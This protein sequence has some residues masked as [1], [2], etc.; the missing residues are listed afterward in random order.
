MGES[1][2][3]ENVGA[4]GLAERGCLGLADGRELGCGIDDGAVVLAQ[5]NGWTVVVLDGGGVTGLR[6]GRR[7]SVHGGL[8][9]D[10]KGRDQPTGPLSCEGGNRVRTR[11]A[12]KEAQNLDGQ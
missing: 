12:V 8:G 6:E 2:E 4:E 7:E 9:S 10:T 5:L 3:T 11:S 1:R